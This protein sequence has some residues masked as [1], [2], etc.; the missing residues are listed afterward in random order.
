MKISL[1]V[2]SLF[3][4]L[5]LFAQPQPQGNRPSAEEMAKMQ[6][7]TMVDELKLSDKQTQE[8]SAI[9]LK[10]MKKIT[11]ALESIKGDREAMRSKMNE[12]RTQMAAEFKAVLTAD[13]FVQLQEMEQKVRNERR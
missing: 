10:Y 8:V 1:L 11:E 5:S 2:V 12:L 9:N 7:Q 3:F 6:T 13:Q 4:A